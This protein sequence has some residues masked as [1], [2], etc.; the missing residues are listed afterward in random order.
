MAYDT[1][2]AD[3]V[4]ELVALERGVDEKRMFGGLAFLIGGHLAVAVSGKGGIMVRVALEDGER[5]LAGPHVEPMTMAGRE[6]RGWLRVAPEGIATSRQ[7][8]AWVKR[9]VDIAKALP[10]K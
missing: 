9:G 7:L 3:R 1:E 5:L 10:P 4:R 8:S 6:T 2:L